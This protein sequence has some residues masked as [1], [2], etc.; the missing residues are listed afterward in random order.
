MAPSALHNLT[1]LW[2]FSMWALDMIS[3]IE[4][5][6]S[7]GYRF[8]LVAIDY[9][10]KSIE[11]A[12]YANVT[13]SVVIKFIKRDIICCYGLPARIITDNGTNLNNK[14]MTEVGRIRMDPEPAR[15][16]ELNRREASNRHMPRA[17]IPVKDEDHFQ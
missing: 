5:K 15:P 2:L 8:I 17:T 4:P 16:I 13:K 1:S 6:A 11:A 9:C 12:L 10:T 3:L 14:M 7:N